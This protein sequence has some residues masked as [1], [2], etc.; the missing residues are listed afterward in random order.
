MTDHQEEFLND[1]FNNVS[2]LN[3]EKA[4]ELAEK[5]REISR[6]GLTGPWGMLLTH[7][8][9]V[10][11]AERSYVDLGFFVTK[12]KG[13]L[14]KD[15]SLKSMYDGLRTDLSRLE[16]LTR[17][18]GPDKTVNTV[19]NQLTQ[20]L[21][22]RIEL[23]DLYEKMQVMGTGKQM[24]YE[25]LV[26][27]IECIVEKHSLSF[28]HMALTSIKAA[29]SLECEI[30][31]HLLRA[32]VEMQMW[33]FLQSLM[34]LHGANTRLLAWE[35]KL[36]NRESRKLGFLKANQ[37]PAVFQWC[38]KLKAAFVSKFT[39][40]F[41][42]TL[43][44]Q[45]SFADM[46]QQCGKLSCDYYQKIHNFQRRYD[47]AAVTLLFDATG[48]EDFKGSGYH[49][50]NK[51]LD[52]PTGIDCYQI[53]FSHPAQKPVNYLP[54]IVNVIQENAAELMAMDQVIYHFCPRDRTTYFLSSVDPRIT[55]VVIFDCKKTEKETNITHFITDISS[56]L[57]CNKVFANL[58]PSSK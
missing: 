1:F 6:L 44:K 20:F 13:F 28:P 51:P 2:Q 17:S 38:L 42:T 19:A 33:R 18:S 11:L 41:F 10:A 32:Q 31:D 56:Q 46:R 53:I 49:H 14:R 25:E 15:N 50:P 22:A 3:F 5:E 43:V 35:N 8:S 39:L 21:T 12:N 34:L 57:R 55:L 54:I 37:L 52:P 36:Q 26:S 9:Q 24:Q 48:V 47:A 16:E 27:H 23:I 7:L 45:T 40:Y 4:R 30:L 58:K 29:L